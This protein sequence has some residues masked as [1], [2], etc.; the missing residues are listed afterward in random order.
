[1]AHTYNTRS[2]RGTKSLPTAA[3]ESIKPARQ[4]A[5]SS[6]SS[7]QL[8]S[9]HAVTI[10]ESSSTSE[11]VFNSGILPKLGAFVAAGGIITTVYSFGK[12]AAYNAAVHGAKWLGWATVNQATGLNN[13]SENANP[14]MRYI[15]TYTQLR[16][17]AQAGYF[18]GYL[19]IT[20]SIAALLGAAF[21]AHLVYKKCMQ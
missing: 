17:E 9:K 14:V 20:L 11:A 21:T 2:K 18:E 19:N 13:D 6:V 16:Q 15:S 7:S 4:A 10:E 8:R 5:T 1:M 3:P 12:D